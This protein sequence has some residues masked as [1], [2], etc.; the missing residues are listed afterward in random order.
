M[1]PIITIPVLIVGGGPVGL[2]ASILLSRH[3]V[4][5]LLVERN[6]TTAYHPK[7]TVINA[8][9]MELFRQWGIEAQVRA[10]GVPQELMLHM[11]WV[12]S[13]S[14]EEL[15]RYSLSDEPAR[16]LS[17]LGAGPA[18]P[19]ICPQ[20]IVE[21]LLLEKARASA[22]ADIR[23][24]TELLSFAQ[25]AVGVTA[26]IRD[27]QGEAQEVR[28]QYLLAADG[29]ASPIRRQLGIPLEG[30]SDLGSVV[31]IYVAADLER[32]A[33]R[34]PAFLYWLVNPLAN[35]VLIALDGGKR[36]LLNLPLQP[37]EAV[38]DYTAERA[39]ATM[40]A[41]VGQPDL[42]VEVRGISPW[43]AQAQVAARYRAGRVLLVG[44]AA[45]RFPPTAGFGMNTGLQDAHN[46]I[47]KLT[48]VLEGSAAESLLDTYE[49]ERRPVAQSNANLSAANFAKLGSAGVG[50]EGAALVASLEAGGQ[51]AAEARATIVAMARM[52]GGHFDFS[53]QELGF[54]YRSAAV[55]PDGSVA[56]QPTDPVRDYIPNARPGARAP[57]RWL[58]QGGRV[59]SSLDLFD[60]FTL[61]AGEDGEAWARAARGLGLPLR[62]YRL[63]HDLIDASGLEQSRERLAGSMSLSLRARIGLLFGVLRELG[64][65]GLLALNGGTLREAYGLHREG[66]VLV[67]PDGHVAWRSVDRV[68]DPDRTLAGV[69]AAV[70]GARTR[71]RTNPL[72]AIAEVTPS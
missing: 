7:A 68:V 14:G 38:E 28:A 21:P 20:D 69:I 72:A 30:P 5:S 13:L 58:R 32:W 41:A 17:R 35:G 36:W 26:T 16:L 18:M 9:S 50:P 53:G 11:R 63:G 64:P 44:D 70:L 56:P 23:F 67:R 54:S 24:A 49:D 27:Q 65:G 12:R 33:V 37:G 52:Q 55:I 3:G 42:A 62:V 15:A 8:R 48:A 19:A 10:Q 60:G 6:A 31:N 29:A 61:L 4:R 2:A 40:R 71:A 45:H 43:R 51:P 39:V 46:L 22:L 57:H 34:R 59:I 47:W 66:A 1:H 25:D